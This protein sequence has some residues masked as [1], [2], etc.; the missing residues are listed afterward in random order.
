[1]MWLYDYLF[2][3]T[4]S[5]IF[6]NVFWGYIITFH[7]E[8]SLM[9]P[10][11]ISFLWVCIELFSY[12]DRESNCCSPYS[13]LA[14]VNCLTNWM[15]WKLCSRNYKTDHE[16]VAALPQIPGTF[17]SH[18]PVRS[19][20]LMRG[21]MPGSPVHSSIY[22]PREGAR[23][24]VGLISEACQTSSRVELS[25]GTSTSCYVV[26]ISGESEWKLLSWA[27]ST[28]RIMTNNKSLFKALYL[29]VVLLHR[30]R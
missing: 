12:Q 24:A 4:F 14:S 7:T 22:T 5:S 6:T 11:S 13:D 19:P 25:G 10:Q 8:P 18:H 17:P 28:F 20:R 30:K 15:L 2:L 9:I 21:D 16:K 26:T 3:F 23:I 29:Q 27:Q 1:M